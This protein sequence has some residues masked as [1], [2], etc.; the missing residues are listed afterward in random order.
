MNN[1]QTYKKCLPVISESIKQL[2]KNHGFLDIS[3]YSSQKTYRHVF[4]LPSKGEIPQ[5][6]IHLSIKA[7]STWAVHVHGKEV[8][9]DNPILQNLP[10]VFDND[11][12]LQILKDVSFSRVCRGNDDYRDSITRRT[13]YCCNFK[14]KKGIVKGVIETANMNGLDD[15]VT[16]RVVTCELL[17]SKTTWKCGACVRYRRSLYSNRKRSLAGTTSP[18]KSKK[19]DTKDLENLQ[20]IS[21][22]DSEFG[23]IH[24]VQSLVEIDHS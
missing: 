13:A 15:L 17:V 3:M 6:N 10:L 1:I 5:M 7:D 4:A 12:A 9:G 2:A 22:Y 18:V 8:P 20:E 24:A 14:D 23:Q 16:V 21:V 19:S 11:S